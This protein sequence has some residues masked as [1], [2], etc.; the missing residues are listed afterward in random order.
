M[1][2]L[3]FNGG[4]IAF[5]NIFSF[6]RKLSTVSMLNDINDSIHVKFYI[7]VETMDQ[8]SIRIHEVEIE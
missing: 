3:I 6:Q 1:I 7:L 4:S 8:S 5:M 2:D